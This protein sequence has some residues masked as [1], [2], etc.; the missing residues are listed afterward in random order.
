M[1]DAAEEEAGEPA[2][3][4]AADDYE[5]GLAVPGFC[6]DL[7]G[8]VTERR[9]GRNP[10]RALR[11]SRSTRTVEHGLGRREG[12]FG[13]G[14]LDMLYPRIFLEGRLDTRGEVRNDRQQNELGIVFVR[15][16]SGKI[17]CL[18]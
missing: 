11:L 17:D 16:I 1:R 2:M 6:D 14:F 12:E 4:T 18:E 7:L 10:A 8:G 13:C 5:I 15:Q 9:L 3:A